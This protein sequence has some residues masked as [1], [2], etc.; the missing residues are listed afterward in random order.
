MQGNENVEMILDVFEI[1]NA[2]DMQ[3]GMM[4]MNNVST[5]FNVDIFLYAHHERCVMWQVIE[6]GKTWPFDEVFASTDAFFR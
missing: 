1:V 2:H 3:Q 5:A 6:E 4:L